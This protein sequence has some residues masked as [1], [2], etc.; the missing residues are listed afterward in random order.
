MFITYKMSRIDHQFN[1]K[2]L[3]DLALMGVGVHHAG[4]SFDDRRAAEDLY[5]KQILRVIVST[6]VSLDYL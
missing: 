2:V 4:L 5:L 1:D 6:S 3:A